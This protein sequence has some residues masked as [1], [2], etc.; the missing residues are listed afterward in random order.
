[1]CSV[2]Y[3]TYIHS[4]PLFCPL[5]A[6]FQFSCATKPHTHIY[7]LTVKIPKRI[8]HASISYTISTSL[9]YRK[10]LWNNQSIVQRKIL[11]NLFTLT[12]SK[13]MVWYLVASFFFGI[14]K[15]KFCIGDW[16]TDSILKQEREMK[17][18]Q[19]CS[20]NNMHVS[21]N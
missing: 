13:W 2:T 4:E 17:K 5:L 10:P 11:T 18:K 9:T 12:Y 20:N 6:L 14:R 19:N 15:L 21:V 16:L 1:M 8:T 7:N 3:T